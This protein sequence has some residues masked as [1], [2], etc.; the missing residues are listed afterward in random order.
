MLSLHMCRCIINYVSNPGE[1]RC[2]AMCV[3]LTELCVS[4]TEMC[5][6]TNEVAEVAEHDPM[7]LKDMSQLNQNP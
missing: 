7:F 4:L 2:T 3:S 1:R 5:A 6:D